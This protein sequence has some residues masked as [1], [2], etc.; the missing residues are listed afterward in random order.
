MNVEE[1]ESKMGNALAFSSREVEVPEPRAYPNIKPCNHVWYMS[2]TSLDVVP[3][4][5]NE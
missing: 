2:T 4:Y 5:S 3:F 1:T